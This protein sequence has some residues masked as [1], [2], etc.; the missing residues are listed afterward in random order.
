MGQQPFGAS[1]CPRLAQAEAIHA[2]G[3][4]VVIKHTDGNTWDFPRMIDA[5]IEAGTASGHAS[6]WT[7]ACSKERFGSA[8]TFF[9]GVNLARRSSPAPRRR[10]SEA[11]YAITHAAR[12]GGLVVVTCGKVL[13]PGTRTAN[14][15]QPRQPFASRRLIRFATPC[16]QGGAG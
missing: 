2:R 15:W 6:A 7:C 5:G 3:G 11:L 13:Q 4:G 1:C 9:G 14:T 16:G 8:L 12:G 10:R